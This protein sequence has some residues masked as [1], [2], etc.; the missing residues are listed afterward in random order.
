LIDKRFSASRSEGE[1]E[2]EGGG[3]FKSSH[4]NSGGSCVEV[5]IDA[6]GT[7]IRDSKDGR[8]RPPVLSISREGW[9]AFLNVLG[10]R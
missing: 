5:K 1:G 6:D 8:A 3:W 7:L 2:G 9:S 4:S 10:R